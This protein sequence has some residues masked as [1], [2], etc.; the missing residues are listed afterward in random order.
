M[1]DFRFFLEPGGGELAT[2]A[3]VFCVGD[4]EAVF[5]QDG[6][7]AGGS[8]EVEM[9]RDVRPKPA[10]LVVLEAVGLAVGGFDDE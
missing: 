5:D 10:A 8:E 6:A 2:E 1:P 4:G 7:E 3:V 9:A